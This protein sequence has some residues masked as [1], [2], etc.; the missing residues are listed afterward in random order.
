MP[1]TEVTNT[2]AA[3]AQPI[4]AGT[5]PGRIRL[6]SPIAWI[7]LVVLIG[8][9]IVSVQVFNIPSYILPRPEAVVRALWSGLAVNPTS[10]LGYYLPLW[11]TLSNAAI[12]F[13]IGVALG[14]VIGSL[15]AEVP[16]I[17]RLVMPYAFALQSLP[18]VAIAP[19]VVIWFGFGDGSKIAIAALLSFFPVLINS[20][21]GLRAVEPERLDLMRSLSATRF[22]TYRIVKLPN[23]A[24]FIFAGLDMAV[25]YALLGAIVAEFLGA[26]RGMGV[27]I[28]QA[29]AV[30]D[31]AGVFAALVILGLLGIV[32]HAIV[33]WTEVR[34]VHWGA[35]RNK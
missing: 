3:P 4:P 7:G 35:N 1:M 15:M 6:G 29:Q 5:K 14:L 33:R 22:E 16:A 12:G 20:F 34:V 18:K 31:V 32:L 13:A 19:L 24:P 10:S 25:V 8:A 11:G 21:T 9:W 30:S 26:Q 28:T 17:E 27:V 23:A 2:A